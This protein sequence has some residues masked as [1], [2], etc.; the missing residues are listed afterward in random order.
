MRVESFRDGDGTMVP[1]GS[2][3]SPA[4]ELSLFPDDER[5]CP[6]LPPGQAHAP[7]SFGKRSFNPERAQCYGSRPAGA[8]RASRARRALMLPPAE[9]PRACPLLGDGRRGRPRPADRPSGSV[10]DQAVKPSW[11]DLAGHA[12]RGSRDQSRDG[13]DPASN[14]DFTRPVLLGGRPRVLFSGMIA[15]RARISPPQ[16]PC[17]SPRCTAPARQARRTGQ[18]WQYALASCRSAGRSENHSWGF[19]RWHGSG[20]S[21]AF[22]WVVSKIRE[23][24]MTCYRPGPARCGGSCRTAPG[25]HGN[26]CCDGRSGG[27]ARCPGRAGRWPVALAVRCPTRDGAW[28][29]GSVACEASLPIGPAASVNVIDAGQVCVPKVTKAWHAARHPKVAMPG[30]ILRSG[31]GT[32]VPSVFALV[33]RGYWQDYRAGW[34]IMV[35]P[36]FAA[37]SEVASERDVLLATKLHVPRPRPD[38]VPRPQLA[39]RLDRGLARGLVL[40]CAPAGYG[41]TVLLADWARRGQQPVA[42]LSLDAG[43]N[44]PARFWRHAVAALDQ[45]RPGLAERVGPAAR[46]ARAFVVPGTGDRADQRTGRRAGCRPGAA[47]ARRLPPD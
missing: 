38:L 44:D 11:P 1:P 19:S 29:S 41:K 9:V 37:P 25:R 40:V 27:R 36:P 32:E 23:L 39:E 31:E 30:G 42:W 2:A 4:R 33:V 26:V 34:G 45:M 43:D 17:G 46:A 16:T 12:G 6:A 5:Y 24:A 28:P 15:P 35:E 18:G 13:G 10:P 22:A 3:P 21:S 14:Y 20:S 7:A 8:S 47:S